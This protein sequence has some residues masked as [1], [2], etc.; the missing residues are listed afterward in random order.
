M[1]LYGLLLCLIPLFLYYVITRFCVRDQ[2]HHTIYKL[3]FKPLIENLDMDRRPKLKPTKRT[4]RNLFETSPDTAREAFNRIQFDSD[5]DSDNSD[6]EHYYNQAI[7]RIEIADC[8]LGELLAKASKIAR[9]DSQEADKLQ[10]LFDEIYNRLIFAIGTNEINQRPQ[11]IPPTTTQDQEK[12]KNRPVINQPPII[13][14]SD[15]I[16]EVDNTIGQALADFDLKNADNT[17][18]F[19]DELNRLDQDDS[20]CSS[21]SIDRPATKLFRLTPRRPT[22]LNIRKR[23]SSTPI[24]EDEDALAAASTLLNFPNLDITQHQKETAV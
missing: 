15:S 16:D 24:E 18:P 19:K 21:Y 20:D 11:K 13:I 9:R 1:F 12:D 7:R 3:T 10:D 2:F 8:S 23:Q 22:S 14:D 4:N 6:C 17:R 5:N